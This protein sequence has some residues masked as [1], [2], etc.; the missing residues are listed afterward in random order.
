MRYW[1]LTVAVPDEASEGL[2]NF[3]WELGALGVVEDERPG[4]RPRLRAFFPDAHDTDTLPARVQ[5]YLDGLRALGFAGGGGPRLAPIADEDWAEAWRAHFA[6]MEVGRSLLVTP[7]WQQ[8]APNGR[9]VITIEPGRAFGTG[10]HGSTSGCLRLVEDI[11]ERDRPPRALDIGTGS[12][13]LAIAAVKLGVASAIAIDSDPDAVAAA[14]GNA[15]RNGMAERVS[16]RVADVET[17]TTEPAPLV[18]ANLL[19]AAHRRLGARYRT[20]LEAGGAL[21]L[22]GILDAERDGVVATLAG[23]GLRAGRALSVE[24]WTSLELRHDAPVHDRP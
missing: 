14:A 24:G 9:A 16:A 19:A 15:A 5:Q 12:G 13:I 10:Q 8:P 4:E 1:E 20:Y 2:T 23:H 22:G 21:V 18:L 7:P 11:V 6:P 3:V 17:F